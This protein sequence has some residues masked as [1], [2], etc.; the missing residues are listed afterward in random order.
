MNIQDEKPCFPFIFSYHQY[1]YSF[2]AQVQKRK[3]VMS[4]D[5]FMEIESF[6]P[7]IINKFQSL[8]KPKPTIKSS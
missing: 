1:Y 8:K 2:M 3:Q 7:P 6:L 4:I 5:L